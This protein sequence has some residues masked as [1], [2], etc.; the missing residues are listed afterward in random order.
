MRTFFEVVEWLRWQGEPPE[1]T[2]EH[3]WTV[4]LFLGDWMKVCWVGYGFRF[5][6]EL[7]QS[8]WC[9]SFDQM[10]DWPPC[11]IARLLWNEYQIL[12]DFLAV[13]PLCNIRNRSLKLKNFCCK[14]CQYPAKMAGISCDRWF[15][16]NQS[17][18]VDWFD[19]CL[20]ECYRLM[21][22]K[23]AGCNSKMDVV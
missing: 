8:E 21:K 1:P 6:E 23:T 3:R 10:L 20:I 22:L 9:R 15:L 13:P 18:S 12:F 14:C 4:G 2:V 5:P 7:P 11:P 17:V 19:G 16:Q